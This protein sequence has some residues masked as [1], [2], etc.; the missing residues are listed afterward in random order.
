LVVEKI[1][2]KRSQDR[3]VV[4][5]GELM[6]GGFTYHLLKGKISRARQA[7]ANCAVPAGEHTTRNSTALSRQVRWL[8][9]WVFAVLGEIE[10]VYEN[11]PTEKHYFRNRGN[12][13]Q[14]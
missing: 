9:K 14:T 4:Q 3:P 6:P 8:V 7:R 5:P 11:R 13:A 2:T 10:A 1:S 12:A